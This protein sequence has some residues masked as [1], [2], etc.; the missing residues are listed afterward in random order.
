MIFATV[1]L[2]Y[3]GFER[4]IRKMDELAGEIDEEVIIQTGHT[5]YQPRNAAFFAFA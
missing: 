4:L 3:M 1:G 2:H 5:K